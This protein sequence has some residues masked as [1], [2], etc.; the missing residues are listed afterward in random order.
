MVDKISPEQEEFFKQSF[1]EFDQDGDGRI[2]S[3]ELKSVFEKV[4]LN[5]SE[6]EIQKMVNYSCYLQYSFY[7]LIYLQIEYKKR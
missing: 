6:E 1:K 2:T 5:H 3:S 4:G 7:C